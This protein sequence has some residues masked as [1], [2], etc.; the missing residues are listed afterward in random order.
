MNLIRTAWGGGVLNHFFGVMILIVLFA[1]GKAMAEAGGRKIITAGL[2]QASGFEATRSFKGEDG[3]T[4]VA[5]DIRSEQV[6]LVTVVANVSQN[7]MVPFADIVSVELSEDGH[8]VTKTNRGSQAAGGLI[9]GLALGPAGLLLGG[10]SG[11]STTKN[12]VSRIDVHI[13]VNDL[14][15]PMHVVNF[16]NSQTSKPGFVYKQSI[17][18]AQELMAL[19]TV[20]IKKS[21][22]EKEVA[23]QSPAR[24]PVPPPS[25]PMLSLADEL[26]KL[27]ALR[28]EGILSAEEFEAQKSR[29]LS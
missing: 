22:V 15:S 29:L 1:I 28:D 26:C 2:A 14:S 25:V 8:T 19:L 3:K 4:G 9:G 7:R 17:A 21:S 10:L 27:A 24:L 13:I 16:L 20:V 23:V 5:L 11:G 6:C 12:K 18:K